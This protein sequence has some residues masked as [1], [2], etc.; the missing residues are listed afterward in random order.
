[1]TTLLLIR[2][3]ENAFTKTGRLA[4]WTPGVQL[5]ETGR[6]QAEQVAE[7]LKGAPI[8][9]LYASPLERTMETAEPLARALSLAIQPCEGLGEVRYG[10]WQ[11][12]SL[13]RLSRQKLWRVVQQHPSAMVF[14]EGETLRA[15][16]ARAVD[17]VEAIVRAHPKAMVAAVSHAD[18]IKLVVAHYL[19]LPLDLFQRL[20][21]GTASVTT[22]QLGSGAPGLLR[23]NDTCGIDA[24]PAPPKRPGARPTRKPAR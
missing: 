3:G 10:R 7:K 5:N 2:H 24:P 23:L 9:A 21:I 8:A 16:Q 15:V 1:M 14:P 20:H 13:K 17:A 22:L 19:G 6:R 11:G 18:V 12:Q 4:G